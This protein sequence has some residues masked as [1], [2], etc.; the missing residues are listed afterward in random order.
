MEDHPLMYLKSWGL[1]DPPD[2][3]SVIKAY[4]KRAQKLHPDRAGNTPQ[5]N[6]QFIQLRHQY[7]LLLKYSSDPG[8]FTPPSNNQHTSSPPHGPRPSPVAPIYRSPPSLSQAWVVP[9]GNLTL[10]KSWPLSLAWTGGSLLL[11]FSRGIP[12]GC[13]V[14]CQN[15]RG[16]LMRVEAVSVHVSVP[17]LPSPQARVRLPGMGHRGDMGLVGTATIE[18]SWTGMRAWRW[19]QDVLYKTIKVPRRTPWI[20]CRAPDAQWCRISGETPSYEWVSPAGLRAVVK[21]KPSLKVM[22]IPQSYRAI[23]WALSRNAPL[24]SRLRM[25]CPAIAQCWSTGPTISG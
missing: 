6:E 8:S 2:R 5:A 18:L 20:Y 4:R 16:T 1:K 12:C 15:C 9:P 25:I 7:Q 3:L 21:I 22:A 14:G 19:K 17:P 24:S 23:R 13:Q 10:R 11:G